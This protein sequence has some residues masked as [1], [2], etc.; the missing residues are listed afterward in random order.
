M[1][2]LM[3]YE[4]SADYLE[5]RAEFRDAHLKLAWQ[6]AE[7]GEIVLAGALDAP[8]DRA[9]L[10]FQGDS[11][12]AAEAFARNDPY[13]VNGLVERWQVRK[14]NTVVGEDAATPVR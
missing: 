6:A 2:Y 1:H 14:W 7:R 13:V 9:I 10:L 3:I 8:A 5:R 12:A 11:P 4:L